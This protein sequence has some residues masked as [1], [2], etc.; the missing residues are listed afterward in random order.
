LLHIARKPK[1]RKLEMHEAD[2]VARATMS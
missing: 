1:E 2:W